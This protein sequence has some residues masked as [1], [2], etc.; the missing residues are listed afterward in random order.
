MESRSCSMT[1][2][3]CSRKVE[4]FQRKWGLFKKSRLHSRN[5][6]SFQGKVKLYVS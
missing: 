4:L 6:E 5:V 2:R 3:D 1:S